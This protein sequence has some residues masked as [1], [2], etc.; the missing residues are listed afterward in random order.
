MKVPVAHASFL[1][2][3]KVPSSGRQSGRCE[4]RRSE[5]RGILKI[6]LAVAGISH[7]S[8]APTL[9]RIRTADMISSCRLEKEVQKDY[10]ESAGSTKKLFTKKRSSSWRFLS[11]RFWDSFPSGKAIW[12]HVL[13]K[14][15]RNSP[16]LRSP[17]L[18]CVFSLMICCIQRSKAPFPGQAV[19]GKELH[20][21][22]CNISKLYSHI[23]V[24][25]LVTLC[26]TLT[27][28]S[29]FLHLILVQS[30]FPLIV[31][32]AG[33]D[34]LHYIYTLFDAVIRPSQGHQLI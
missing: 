10:R 2:R 26:A 24:L 23:R 22:E 6:A 7:L 8:H 1:E 16:F 14:P 28:L 32:G 21:S 29:V 18:S 33:F 34:I 13:Q 15:P 20:F 5:K 11:M 17:V 4:Q 27:W 30:I 9:L 25:A 31:Q 12:G 19:P 3:K